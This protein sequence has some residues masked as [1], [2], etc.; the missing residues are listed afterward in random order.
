ME[1][2]NSAAFAVF[3]GIHVLAAPLFAVGYVLFV[4]KMLLYARKSG[5]SGTILASFYT[6]WMQHQLRTRRDV[7][8]ARIMRVLPNVS[9]LGLRLFT[10]PTIL[11]HRLTGYVPRIYRYPYPGQPPMND[12][13]AAR[14]TYFDQALAR[15]LRTIDQLVILGAGLD[16]RPYRLPPGVRI[17]CFEVDTPKTQA[18]ARAMLRKAGIDASHVTFVAADFEREDWFQKLVAAGFEPDKPT[19]FLWEGVTPYLD[20]QAVESTLRKIA[21]TAPGGAVAF[22]YFSTELFQE[23]SLFW[24]YARAALRAFREPMGSFGLDTSPP[25]REH[26]AAFLASCGLSLEEHRNFGEETAQSR[27]QA[28]FVTATVTSGR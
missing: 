23:T 21:G 28:G 24:R 7:A 12:E 4:L 16:T 27:P 11:A 13:P 15:H 5:A 19:F 25:A 3:W 6:R 9:P 2:R 14:T 1:Q 17:R 22:D 18:F 10:G 8:C 20:R 26:A